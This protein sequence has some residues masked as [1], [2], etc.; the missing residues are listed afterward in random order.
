MEMFPKRFKQREEGWNGIQNF[1]LREGTE[2]SLKGYWLKRALLGLRPAWSQLV[3]FGS[4][5]DRCTVTFGTIT[6]VTVLL[7]RAN[8]YRKAFTNVI[9]TLKR[10]L[11]VSSAAVV[12]SLMR[13]KFILLSNLA[14]SVPHFHWLVPINLIK[15]ICPSLF[16]F[17]L[18]PH[19]SV[20]SLLLL[21]EQLNV[22]DKQMNICEFLCDAFQLTVKHVQTVFPV[23][24][25]NITPM[26]WQQNW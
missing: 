12:L 25:P 16:H 2:S 8:R 4:S 13:I 26:S 20:S 24:F 1:T 22:S 15:H 3:A 18:D 6:C 19:H 21:H 23:P 17:H 9:I 11:S 5:Y 10:S 14:T 7:R